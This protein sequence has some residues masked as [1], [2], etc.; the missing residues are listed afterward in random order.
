[1]TPTSDDSPPRAFAVLPA[2]GRSVRMGRPKLLLP[3]GGEG[4]TLVEAVVAAWRAAGVDAIVATVHRDDVPLAERLR[5][6]GVAVVVPIVPPPDMKASVA[7]ALEFIATTY[8]PNAADVWL[9]APSDMPGLS[10]T[11][12]RQLLATHDRR[13]P[14]I[15][16]P[17]HAGRRGHPLLVPWSAVDEVKN[18]P[19]DRG[20]DALCERFPC[21]DIACDAACL[22]TDVDTP[23]DYARLR[24]PQNDMR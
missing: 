21:L 13:R 23:E 14:V 16:R 4:R 7:A 18:I 20:L 24:P 6:V 12:I 19:P 22:S 15:L 1:M 17:T 10:P 3:W 11:V 9:L 2:A 5:S 8:R